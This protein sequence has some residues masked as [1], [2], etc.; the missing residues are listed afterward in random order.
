VK[1]KRRRNKK[2]GKNHL[3]P[4]IETSATSAIGVRKGEE[5]KKKKKTLRRQ[6]GGLMAVVGYSISPRRGEIGGRSKG[7]SKSRCL[8][9]RCPLRRGRKKRKGGREKKGKENG[10]HSTTFNL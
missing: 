10:E 5:R 2:K 7:T 8:Q 4:K 9:T 6:K 3:P 1:A